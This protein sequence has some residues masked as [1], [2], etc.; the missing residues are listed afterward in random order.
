M[1]DAVPAKPDNLF[2]VCH[3]LGETFRFDPLYLRIAVALG[4]L[5]NFEVTVIT[6]F[7][8]GAAVLAATLL[9]GG[10]RGRQSGGGSLI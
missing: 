8:V 3:T 6:Y 10:R 7:A 5:V 1:S 2:G 9:S 4:L